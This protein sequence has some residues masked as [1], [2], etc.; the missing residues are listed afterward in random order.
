MHI[1]ITSNDKTLGMF[2]ITVY[3]PSNNNIINVTRVFI[4]YEG[5]DKYNM[6]FRF[7]RRIDS[8]RDGHEKKQHGPDI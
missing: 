2:Y 1:C 8:Q 3:I 4:L 7:Y 5:V 6:I